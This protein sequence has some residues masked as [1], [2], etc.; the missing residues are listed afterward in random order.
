MLEVRTEPSSCP[1]YFPSQG[2]GKAGGAELGG[3]S[4]RAQE[5]LPPL[6]HTLRHG[7]PEPGKGR[8]SLVEAQS[9]HSL[10]NAELK[11]PRVNLLCSLTSNYF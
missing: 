5:P 1:C 3:M 2:S 8:G 11:L 7:F 6:L 10:Q 9:S 4:V